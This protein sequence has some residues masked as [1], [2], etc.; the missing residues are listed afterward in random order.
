MFVVPSGVRLAT[1]P[2]G[3]GRVGLRRA[4]T[5]A[6]TGAQYA[7]RARAERHVLRLDRRPGRCRERRLGRGRTGGTFD[8]HHCDR[9]AD[10][11]SRQQQ[12]GAELAAAHASGS[13]HPVNLGRRVPFVLG[14]DVT[15]FVD[16]TRRD[17]LA[18]DVG[19]S[20]TSAAGTIPAM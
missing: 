17:T 11:R 2:A 7:D 19:L 3:C 12:G 10:Q 9:G 15:K 20:T 5:G 16:L 13:P 14:T 18:L 6:R 8:R 1:M 4:V